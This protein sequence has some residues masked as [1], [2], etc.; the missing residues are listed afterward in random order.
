MI[1]Q[2]VIEVEYKNIPIIMA[3]VPDGLIPVQKTSLR[4]DEP[5]DEHMIIKAL[6]R[7]YD[8]WFRY[9]DLHIKQFFIKD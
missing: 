3:L 8:G 1:N 7:D 5:Y 4:V 9:E 2:K 6:M